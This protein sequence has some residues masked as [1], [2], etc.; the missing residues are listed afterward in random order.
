MELG[1]EGRVAPFKQLVSKSFEH[2]IG[3]LVVIFAHKRETNTFESP[4]ARNGRFH[5]TDKFHKCCPRPFPSS[6]GK[7]ENR[8]HAVGFQKSVIDI[9][10]VVSN[11]LGHIAI[12][13]EVFAN[14]H[15]KTRVAIETSKM[16]QKAVDRG[17]WWVVI[18]CVMKNEFRARRT[19]H[20]PVRE[21]A[22][23][24]TNQENDRVCTTKRVFGAG[25]R[26]GMW[27]VFQNVQEVVNGAESGFRTRVN[28]FNLE[29]SF[30]GPRGKK[31]VCHNVP[32]ETRPDRGVL[33][34]MSVPMDVTNDAFY[35]GPAI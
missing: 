5:D 35:H 31:G 16:L 28:Q 20:Q 4:Q 14:V 15:V 27:G 18:D 29:R 13:D 11:Q 26:V 10:D 25:V 6:R 17:E 22:V 21:F 1:K 30:H 32:F 9:K 2:S 23:S 19:G 33:E 24:T 7:A 3:L 12:R 8:K 34:Q